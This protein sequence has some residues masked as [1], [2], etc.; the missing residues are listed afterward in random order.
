[1]EPARTSG[2]TIAAAIALAL[3]AL[4]AAGETAARQETAAPPQQPQ[5][6]A[7]QQAPQ[8]EQPAVPA[9]T[10]TVGEFVVQVAAALKLPAP[11]GGFNPESAAFALRGKGVQIETPAAA[12]LTEADAV[13]VLDALGYRVVTKTPSRTVNDQQA[14]LLIETFLT[15]TPS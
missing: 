2:R 10:I 3:V 7:S 1:M 5:D 14:K 13:K 6:E 9:R 11:Q 8:G 15:S 12:V 4:F